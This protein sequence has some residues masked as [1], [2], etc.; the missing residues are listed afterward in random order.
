MAL[1]QPLPAAA[2]QAPRYGLLN[3][4]TLVD[5]NGGHWE[6][7][8]NQETEACNMRIRLLDIC[9]T[10]TTVSAVAASGTRSL[11]A[12]QPFAV[13]TTITCST[14]GINAHDY[15]AQAER[16]IEVAQHKAVER[17]F[18]DGRLAVAASSSNKY[19]A[20]ANAVDV[21]PTPG[22]PV[23]VRYGLALLEQALANSSYGGPGTIHIPRKVASALPIQDVDGDGIFYTALG[24]MVIAGVGYPGTGYVGAAATPTGAVWMYATGPVFVRLGEVTVTPPNPPKQAVNTS[25]NS[26]S[27]SAERPAAV[28]WDGCAQYAVLVDLS[29]DYA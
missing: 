27:V 24:N 7:G 9:S 4:K 22:T 26:I 12:Y 8:F 17:E 19:L 28:V 23:K 11:G 10:S 29:L 2:L 15:R 6:I 13:Q 16:A 3:S 21:T 20:D 18:W 25:D 1:Q 14:F 5:E